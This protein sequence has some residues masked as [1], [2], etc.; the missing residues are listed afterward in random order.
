MYASCCGSRHEHGNRDLSDVRLLLPVRPRAR[1][2]S[3]SRASWREPVASIQRNRRSGHGG[4]LGHER[5]THCGG[6]ALGTPCSTVFALP[7]VP[8]SCYTTLQQPNLTTVLPLP[9]IY[10]AGGVFSLDSMVRQVVAGYSDHGKYVGGQRGRARLGPAPRH[11]RLLFVC[12]PDFI[13][14]ACT[15]GPPPGSAG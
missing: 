14:R 8:S 2:R 4:Q 3:H 6:T 12:S 9:M 1:S 5:T 10:L 15:W 7:G 11:R 13:R